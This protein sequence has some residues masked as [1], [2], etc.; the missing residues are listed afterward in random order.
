MNSPSLLEESEFHSHADALLEV[1]ESAVEAANGDIDTD[2]NAGI[3]T[4]EF[5]NGSKVIVNRQTPNREIWVAAKSGGF[6]FRFIDGNWCDTRT[7]EPLQTLLSR[8]ITEQSGAVMSIA[9]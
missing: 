5:E 3:L 2:I 1:I 7:S 9:L 4:L 8:V 6:H